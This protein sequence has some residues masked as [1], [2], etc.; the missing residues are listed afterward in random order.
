MQ[1][2]LIFDYVGIFMLI[3]MLLYFRP[4]G[5][6][7]LAS[8]RVFYII[9]ISLLLTA[10]LDILTVVYRIQPEMLPKEV[11]AVFNLFNCMIQ[12][13]VIVAYTAYMKAITQ[14]E[15]WLT[16]GW[17]RM[18]YLPYVIAFAIT[19]VFAVRN[20]MIG[21]GGDTFRDHPILKILLIIL[22]FYYLISA[23]IIGLQSQGV[24]GRKRTIHLMLS[25]ILLEGLQIAQMV[26]ARVYIV[27]FFSALVMMH[28]MLSVQ[29]A[30][31]LFESADALKKQVLIRSTEQ[32]YQM[33]HKFFVMFI[34]FL[35]YDV[36]ED[37]IGQED[38]EAFMR[39]VVIY[40]NGLRRDALVF[41]IE[42]GCLVLKL[43]KNEKEERWGKPEEIKEAV[44]RRFTEPWR[45][46]LM[47]SMISAAFVAANCPEE[48]PTMDD[49]QKVV[50][51]IPKA[52]LEAGELLPVRKLLSEN[53]DAHILEA[54]RRALKE[55]TFQVYYQP[56]YSTKE[57]K[58]VAAEALIRLFDP[59]YGFIPP[60]A[61]ITMAEKEGYILE[62]GEIVF[63]EVCR[64]YSENQLDRI[65]IRYIEVN[66]SAVQCMQTRLAEEF[67]E[68]MRKFNLSAEQINF[69]IT[70]TSA[71]ISNAVVSHNISHFELHGISLSLDDY[72]TGYS[73]ISYLYNLPFMFMKID[74]SIL[75]SAESNEKADII[76]R[77]I[78]RMAQR[79][80]LK[81]V[82]EGVE[83]EDQIRKL[84]GLKCDYFQ[85]Y[86]F[87]KP[88][89]GKDFI[90]YVRNFTLP[91]ICKL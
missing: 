72:G 45:S 35:D 4:K 91:E 5:Q 7:A 61:M 73:N 50:N 58:V 81:V 68:I 44:C 24:L 19:T 76:L 27:V 17:S 82:M 66:L 31:E 47:Q 23:L 54:I 64:F 18:I 88:V 14:M 52:D 85:G 3:V 46:G 6:S 8:Y 1:Y 86:Y 49:F 89:C 43:P 56:I 62:I 51:R 42:K 48:I 10:L 39:Q 9:L 30:E 12:L 34:H 67:M 11:V 90:E 84:L 83:T 26:H 28:V 13:F 29:R 15:S 75:W 32:D 41:R 16:K 33:R 22:L 53:E 59:E 40:L 69:E 78:F 57:K 36:L 37:A 74:K 55:N 77:N 60:E 79:L 65:G 21:E 2:N 71:M 25:A 80:H 38:A 20:C 87:S 63:T 70:E